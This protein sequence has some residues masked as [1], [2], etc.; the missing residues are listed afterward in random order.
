MEKLDSKVESVD[1][2]TSLEELRTRIGVNKKYFYKVLFSHD[3]FYREIEI[4]KRKNGQFRKLSV[5]SM[6]LKNMQRWILDNILYNVDVNEKAMGFVPSRSIITNAYNHFAKK[7]ILKLDIKD[8]F[9]S[10]S[11]GMVLGEFQKLNFTTEVA[12]AL[13]NICIYHNEL[14]QGAPTSPYLA[15]LVCRKM[16]SRIQGLCAKHGLNYTRYADDITISGNRRVFWIEKEVEKIISSYHFLLNKEK[17]VRLKPGDRKRVTGIIVNEKISVPKY[18]KR[19]LRQSIYYIDK[20]GLDSHLDRIQFNGSSNQYIRH[21]YGVASFIRMVE[22]K[23]GIDFIEQL[24][25]LFSQTRDVEYQISEDELL[26]FSNINWSILYH[27][28]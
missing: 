28:V 22:I 18:L 14:P 25:I 11:F 24:N 10:I 7:Y 16:D 12:S 26:N 20:Y 6:A 8:F 13:A 27:E 1:S 21:L 19:G 5:P 4:P 23:R 2:I 9:P 3:K 15:N 17:T